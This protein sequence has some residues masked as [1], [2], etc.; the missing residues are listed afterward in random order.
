MKK[1]RLVVTKDESSQ[2]E[3]SGNIE[4]AGKPVASE[5]EIENKVASKLV[6][7]LVS[8]GVTKIIRK[9]GYLPVD[10]LKKEN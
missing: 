2:T 10:Y 5:S 4:A 6:H 9:S 3:H 7:M 1:K 8:K